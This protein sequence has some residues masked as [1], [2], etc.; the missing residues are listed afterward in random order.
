MRRFLALAVLLSASSAAPLEVKFPQATLRGFPDLSDAKGRKIAD[1][2]LVQWVQGER[3]FAR[4]VWSFP[5][6]RRITEETEL[7]QGKELTQTRWS[8]EDRYSGGITRHFEVDFEA[9]RA[10]GF[11]VEG[12]K[13]SDW[14]EKVDV[15]PGKTFAGFGV[16][17]ATANLIDRLRAGEKIE[18]DTV[19]WMPKPRHA[20]VQLSLGKPRSLK[21]G[22]KD[23][24]VDQVVVHPKVPWPINKLLNVQD[25]HLYYFHDDPPQLMRAE[26]SLI[27]V[28]DEQVRI[29]VLPGGQK[30]SRSQARRP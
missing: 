28:K 4:L 1:G 6:G 24:L 16:A 21:R 13:R 25:V 11:K 17:V 30:L 27:E 20:T 9:K 19:A 18:L 2:K 29:D 8:V 12:K 7:H 3:L 5:D 15:T 23:V 26:Q 10:S 22:G 14:S